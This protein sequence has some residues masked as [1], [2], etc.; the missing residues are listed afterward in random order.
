MNKDKNF[1][2]LSITSRISVLQ[3]FHVKSLEIAG[4]HNI[5]TNSLVSTVGCHIN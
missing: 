2:G 3:L 5:S 4:R 1:L